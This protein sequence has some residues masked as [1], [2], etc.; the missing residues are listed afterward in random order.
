MSAAAMTRLIS[1]SWPGNVRE[2]KNTLRRAL[3]LCND[4]LI[5]ESDLKLNTQGAD[6]ESPLPLHSSLEELVEALNR[7]HGR[8]GPVAEEL[9]VS[10]RTIQRRMKD[11]G[12]RLKDF[13][14]N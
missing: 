8:L 14:V 9:G 13:R 4:G 3:A 2:L 11:S 1:A 12:L 6:V 5:N 7:A 10:I